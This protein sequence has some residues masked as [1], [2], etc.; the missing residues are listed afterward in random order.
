MAVAMATAMPTWLAVVFCIML[1]A[2]ATDSGVVEE[3]LPL[4]EFDGGIRQVVRPEGEAS[5]VADSDVGWSSEILF[6]PESGKKPDYTC[7]VCME[8]A[9]E[10]QAVL[11]D[12]DF[13]KA[14]TKYV[15]A[16]ACDHVIQPSLR[17]KCQGVVEQ[18]MPELFVA[19]RNY[20][21]PESLCVSSGFCPKASQGFVVLKRLDPKVCTI[22]LDL[23]T[24]ALQ[25]LEANKTTTDIITALHFACSK[26]QDLQ[27]QCDLLV[28][29][30]APELIRRM[31]STTPEQFC[32]QTK[33]CSKVALR[34]LKDAKDCQICQFIILELKLKLR[35]PATQDKLL[36]V[37]LKSCSR[38]PNHVEECRTLVQQYVPFILSN[39][40]TVLDGDAIC[41]KMGACP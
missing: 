22:C 25:F 21:E 30:Y 39:L 40:D 27:K 3:P 14:T 16:H 37:L 7:E 23:A 32:Q 1:V 34:D 4:S 36:D 31:K 24:D 20:A 13:E 35:D 12:P 26:L 41:A 10:A 17:K 19:L 5:V 9:A 11:T 29:V 38:V 33:L 6:L 28:D 2:H 18:Y 8:L 15:E